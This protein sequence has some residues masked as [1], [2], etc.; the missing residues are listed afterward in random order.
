[1]KEEVLLKIP[2]FQAMTSE[3]L[4][5]I[6]PLLVKRHFKKNEII[7]REEDT[8]LFM[9]A[10]L[11]GQ[12]KV[13]KITEDGKERILSIHNAGDFFGEM[14][15]IDAMTA[16]ATVT[17]QEECTL[18]I[19]S[20]SD[21]RKLLLH[22]NFT[23]Q[24]LL[25]LCKRLRGAWSQMEWL[26]MLNAAEKMRSVFRFLAKHHGEKQDGWI[27]IH[28]RL[29]HAEIGELAGMSRETVSRELNR[30]RGEG[31][32]RTERSDFGVKKKWL[33]DW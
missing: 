32:V 28:L 13:T 30:L 22:Q 31:V 14:S 2:L 24:L 21:F 16:P 19:F 33:Y 9:Y 23:E 7:F 20:R 11:K 25:I 10:I 6:A 1:M 17:A 15:L 8:N 18:I 26:T 12:V 5:Q 29:T 3:Q 4:K 27:K